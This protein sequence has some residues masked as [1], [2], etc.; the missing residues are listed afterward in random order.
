MSFSID[1]LVSG[2]DTASVIEGLVSLQQAQVDRLNVKKAEIATQQ[3]AFQGI[4]VRLLNLRS[5]MNQLNRNSGSAL[6]SNTVT[7]SDDT[8]LTA[9]AAGNVAEGSYLMR[10]NSLARAE[11]LGS[12]GFSSDSNSISEGTISF[13]VGDRPATELTIDSTNNTISGLVSAINAESDDVSASIIH[14]QANNADRILLTS[15]HTGESNSIT[16]TNN[17]AAASGSNVRP[18]FTGTP[19]QSATNASIQLGSGPGAITAEYDTNSVDG[20]I[21][22]VTLDLISVDPDKDVTIN[23]SR[24]SSAA[25]SAIEDFV[26]EFN[27]LISYIDATT[28]YN[29]ETQEGSPLIGNRRVSNLKNT[30]TSMVTNAVPG[31]NSGLNRLSQIGISIGN[32]SELTIDSVK[33]DKA[34]SGNLDGIDPGD[35]KSLFGLNGTSTNSGVEFVLGSSRTEATTGAIQVDILQAAE[36]GSVSATNDLAASIVIDS[37]NN[38]FQIKVDGAESEVLSLS[39][40]TYTRQELADHLQ[41]LI[42]SSADLANREVTVSLQGDALEI[43]SES[44]GQSSNLSNISG[45]AISAM[46]FDGSESGEGKDVAGSFIVNGVVETA[47]G[48]GRVLIGDSENDTTGDL[49]VRVT[50]DPSD[51]GAG[52]ESELSVTRGITSSLDKYFSEVLDPD[53]GTMK[54]ANDDFELRIESLE[55]SI[56]K[57]NAIS[58]A[59]TEYLVAQFTQLERVL[60]ELQTTSGFLSSQLAAG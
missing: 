60:S 29:P 24:D 56:E 10:V 1:G 17:L 20:L 54:I 32:R 26:A 59:K 22:G 36:K 14:D 16:V 57:V 55:S 11:Q 5:T 52:I 48:S 58:A 19:I 33:L 12:Q 27:A 3:S 15:K 4:E 23:I 2:I 6:E 9:Q 31:L 34:L 41:S 28:E 39:E 13:Q 45:S 7:T 43:T 21:E 18:D 30:L 46:G 49:Q 37:S 47:T 42:N 40:G 8:I 38:N 35:I 53:S 25:K 51:V 44:Y 50:L